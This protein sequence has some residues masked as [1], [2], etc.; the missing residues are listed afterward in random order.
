MFRHLPLVLLLTALAL[1]AA[2]EAHDYKLGALTIEHPW[3]RATIGQTRNGAAYLVV[4]TSGEDADKL[5][6]VETAAS[7]RAEIHTHEMVDGVMKMRPVA[8]IAVEPGSPAVL[9][10]GGLHIML[11]DLKAPLVEGES[12]P[13]TLVFEKAGRIEVD[14]HI[15]GVAEMES[16]HEM[17][18]DAGS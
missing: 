6:A 7:R 14:V 10:P 18:H 3:A 1:P 4:N 13:A 9:K 5:I 17:T 2:A 15:Q 12:F 16:G 11:F 8:G